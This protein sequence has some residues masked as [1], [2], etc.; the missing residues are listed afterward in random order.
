MSTSILSQIE[1]LIAS[2]GSGLNATA[3]R[4]DTMANLFRA[5]RAL[6]AMQFTTK[7]QAQKRLVL[8]GYILANYD[9]SIPKKSKKTQAQVLFGWTDLGHAKVAEKVEKAIAESKP[10]EQVENTYKKA[11]TAK[12]VA[13]TKKQS[14][15]EY[16]VKATATL[17]EGIADRLE[18]ADFA[19]SAEADAE[20]ARIEK[21]IATYKATKMVKPVEVKQEESAPK[22][23]EVYA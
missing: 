8:A 22:K 14:S 19:K 16:K 18:K 20:I 12:D 23:E 7:N 21:A 15:G 2:E 13:L 9:V 4:F 5:D 11:L 1:S 17:F 6:T 3:N 10:I